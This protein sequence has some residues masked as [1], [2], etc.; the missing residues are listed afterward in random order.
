MSKVGMKF[1][2]YIDESGEAGI[3][4]VR[5]EN[6]N[7]ASP[8]FVMGAVVCPPAAEDIA[9]KVFSDFCSQIGKTAWKHATELTHSEKVYLAR[10]LGKLPVR[11]FAII[12]N[13]AT[14]NDYKD[15]IENSA[16]KFYN[17]C[18]QYLLEVICA[19]LGPRMQSPDDMNIVFEERNHDYGAMLRLLIKVKDN[20]IQPQSRALKY[21]NPF[22]ITARP[23]GDT[24]MLEIADFVAH[25]VFQCANKSIHNFHIPEPRYL[26]EIW[27]RFAPDDSGKVLGVG[28][29]PIHRLEQLKLEPEVVDMIKSCRA[30]LPSILKN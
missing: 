8:Y 3:A 9:K 1:N 6:T 28:L 13:K 29:K 14:L 2:V 25:A 11:Y 4:K 24:E 5:T 18:A 21:L 23:K 20:P 15:E 16:H 12:S 10:E 19:Y 27:P 26:K 30:E 22:S 17:K 7:G